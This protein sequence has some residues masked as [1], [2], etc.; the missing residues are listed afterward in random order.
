M[1]T[2]REKWEGGDTNTEV[3]VLGLN[4]RL[5]GA[6]QKWSMTTSNIVFTQKMLKKNA[7]VSYKY[8]INYST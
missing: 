2:N 6:G 3:D 7:M 4:I 8:K 5:T 1:N